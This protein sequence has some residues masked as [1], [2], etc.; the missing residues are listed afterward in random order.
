LKS[1]VSVV[2]AGIVAEARAGAFGGDRLDEIIVE[3]GLGIDPFTAHQAR[4]AR[5]ADRSFG[6]GKNPAALNFGDCFAYVLAKTAGWPLLSRATISP[7]Q[8]CCAC[9]RRIRRSAFAAIRA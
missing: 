1:A 8:T 3:L 6:K 5:L 2:E 4:I 7:E 9:N